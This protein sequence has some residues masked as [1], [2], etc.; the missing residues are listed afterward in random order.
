M[1]AIFSSR[2][3][4]H[5]WVSCSWLLTLCG[6]AFLTVGFISVEI[7]DKIR[8][9]EKAQ[10]ALEPGIKEACAG[11][12]CA[13]CRSFIPTRNCTYE[14]EIACSKLQGEYNALET[15]KSDANYLHLYS[16]KTLS[17]V[18]I[19]LGLPLS[20]TMLLLSCVLCFIDIKISEEGETTALCHETRIQ[21]TESSK[22]E[23]ITEGVEGV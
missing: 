1:S 3:Q 11:F 7:S 23:P 4:K 18:G 5:A 10:K 13:G 20:I 12:L 19:I 17:I 16:P 2:R 21:M 22:L 6:I 14:C 9:C 8:D 15:R